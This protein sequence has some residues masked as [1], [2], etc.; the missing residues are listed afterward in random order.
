MFLY[1]DLAGGISVNCTCNAFSLILRTKFCLCAAPSVRWTRR[2][3]LWRKCLIGCIPG[4]SLGVF[5][6][7]LWRQ[8]SWVERD[9][10]NET[11]FNHGEQMAC[12]RAVDQ[13]I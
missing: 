10:T 11:G 9:S 6:G 12:D 5:A 2:A 8:Q 4:Q 3:L 13:L 7:I 1:Y